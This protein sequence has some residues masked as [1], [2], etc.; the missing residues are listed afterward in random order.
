MPRI[1]SAVRRRLIAA[2]AA[3]LIGALALSGCSAAGADTSSAAAMRTVDSE[4]GEV[5]LPV[6]PQQAL[7]FYTTDVDILVTLGIPLAASQPIRGDGY[8][9]YPE[10]F[11]S[12]V[13]EVTTF[14]N[15]PDYNYE[16]VLQAQPD[17]I[18]NGLGYDA[19]AVER[20][21]EIAPTYSINA[22]ADPDWRVTFK[23]IAEAFDRVDEYEAWMAAYQARIDEVKAGL[24]AAGVQPVVA[25]IS[26]NDGA[27]NVS[28]YGVPC[29]VFR[30]LGLTILPIADSYDGTTLSLEQL[31]QLSS[32]DAV[33]TSAT[34]A[35]VAAGTDPFAELA[36]NTVWNQLPFITEQQV[37]THDLEML[38]GSPSGQ[39][40]F[41]DVVEQ[42]L[43][44]QH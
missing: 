2:S 37:F 18:L 31:D 44:P 6:D 40:A 4:F 41:L 28:C 19:E 15:F 30:D 39:M 32:V 33:F 27:V 43:L 3:T 5:S 34:P 24:A 42:A 22:F 13:D 8:D 9:G 26:S 11:P 36:G 38:Y 23:T 14:A 35:D 29:L 12:E 17:V 21:P 1:T 7:G 20:L 10:F 25:P 16:A